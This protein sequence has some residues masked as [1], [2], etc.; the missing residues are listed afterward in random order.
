VIGVGQQVD[1]LSIAEDEPIPA[2]LLAAA[3]RADLVD[4]ACLTTLAATPGVRV[5]ID[6]DDVAVA[7]RFEIRCAGLRTGPG[8]TDLVFSTRIV[9]R[10]A[11]ARVRREH[12][13]PA[14]TDRVALRALGDAATLDATLPREARHSTSAAVDRIAGEVD[15][16]AVA[17]RPF[18]RALDRPGFIA[19]G[20]ATAAHCPGYRRHEDWQ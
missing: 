3:V 8:R 14:L 17:A 11:V 16:A 13:A 12:H 15:A 5:K 4:R 19:A 6:A 1:A 20:I 9:A 18:L 2:F 10:A 7:A